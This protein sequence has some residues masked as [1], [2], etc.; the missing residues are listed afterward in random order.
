VLIPG[1][2]G[3]K[4]LIG[5]V[6]YFSGIADA[7]EESGAQVFQVEV[8]QADDSYVR[9]AEIIPQL[10]S[11]RAQTGAS[12][13]NLVGHSQGA[14]DAR[15]V[16]A[17]RP[18]LVASVTSVGGPHKGAPVADVLLAAPLG[19]GVGGTQALADFFT[20]LSGSSNPNDARACLEFLRP[21]SLQAFNTRYPAAVPSACGEG[22]YAVGG[23][24]YYSWGGVDWLTNPLDIV[25]PTWALL[26]TSGSEPNDG[27]VGKCSSHLGQVIRD[28]YPQN[29]IDETNMVLGLV[30]PIGPNPKTLFRNQANRLKN[31]GL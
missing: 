9:G 12:K 26:G 14:V 5:T 25:D 16:A 10:E 6:E 18:D 28:D 3:F 21:S 30:L 13:L 22:D 24:R 15:Y 4:K 1:F 11:I 23:I 8:R 31:A 17:L 2:L 20:L 19:L 27:L 7:L 29:H